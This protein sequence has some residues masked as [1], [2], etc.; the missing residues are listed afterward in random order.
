MGE[1]AQSEGAHDKRLP[2]ESPVRS[3]SIPPD[4]CGH[5]EPLCT[6]RAAAAGPPGLE[7]RMAAQGEPLHRLPHCPRVL[8]QPVTDPRHVPPLLI[9]RFST[10][11]V[12][13]GPRRQGH[14]DSCPPSH[15]AHRF[16]ASAAAAAMAGTD[17]AMMNSLSAVS[18]PPALAFLH[19][20]GAEVRNVRNRISTN[21]AESVRTGAKCGTSVRKCGIFVRQGSRRPVFN[22]MM[23]EFAAADSSVGADAAPID[24]AKT[25]PP[26]P[27]AAPGAC[28]AAADRFNRCRR[29]RTGWTTSPGRPSRRHSR[30][31]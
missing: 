12:P 3:L 7:P 5:D 17:Q 6:A 11:R 24:S 1:G 23:A 4:D 14:R 9:S 15:C 25:T 13:T 27:C 26:R 31:P 22:P 20:A 19:F 21:D 29:P 30:A 2:A 18:T 28:P 10:R 8:G 16:V